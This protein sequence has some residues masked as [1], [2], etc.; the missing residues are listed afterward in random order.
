MV[1]WLLLVSIL[2][3]CM[4]I[5][6]CVNPTG[7]YGVLS[8]WPQVRAIRKKMMEIMTREASS[9]D[10]KGLVGKLIPEAIGGEIQKACFGEWASAVLV[11]LFAA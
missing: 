11:S 8:C 4:T 2:P 5:V 1:A 6:S 10:L 7:G 3:L 9:V